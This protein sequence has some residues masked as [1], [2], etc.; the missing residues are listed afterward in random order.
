MTDS[1]FFDSMRNRDFVERFLQHRQ[2]HPSPYMDLEADAAYLNGP[3]YFADLD[4]LRRGDYFFDLPIKKYIPKS[5]SDKKRAVY[6]FYGSQ[7]LLLQ[8]MSFALHAYDGRFSSCVFSSILGKS[9]KEYV[10]NLKRDRSFGQMYA[11]KVDI[12]SYGASLDIEILVE[13]LRAFFREDPAAF[14]FFRWLLER[15]EFLLEGE[16]SRGDT[17]GLPGIPIHSFF[18]N[19]YLM[20]L[21][22]KVESLC[23]GYCRYSDDILAF[24]RSPEEAQALMALFT[25]ETARVG[26][27]LNEKKTALYAPHAKF[28]HMGISYEDGRIDLSDFAIYKLKRKM[29]IRAKRL[30]R[31]V[32][33]GA[34]GGEDGAKIL[35]SLNWKTFYGRDNST[36]LCWSRWLFP[37]LTEHAGLH[38][39]DLYFQ[40]C[41]RFILTGKWS[42]SAYR[43][44]YSRLK[45]LGYTSLVRRYYD[46]CTPT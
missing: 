3:E 41:L 37:M 26:L 27:R 22:Q 9:F 40:R 28:D 20:E 36:E 35:I 29:R 33:D 32:E 44:K 11:I 19:L 38:A 23:R 43:I 46:R 24:A 25:A 8:A 12:S 14:E 1:L 13:K 7:K 31:Q 5:L 39:L 21:D 42:D 2:A 6:C 45:E 17:S 34:I 15:R 30:R 4:R 18:T 10:V 16:P